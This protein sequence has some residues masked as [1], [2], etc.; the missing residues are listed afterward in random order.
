M[1]DELLAV[2]AHI[3]LERENSG[4]LFAGFPD[5]L[6]PPS[7]ERAYAIQERAADLRIK[8][9]GSALA[10]YKIGS[11]TPVMQ[12][13][14]GIANPCSGTMIERTVVA[15]GATFEV[16][17][18]GV[19]GVECELAVRLARD[20]PGRELPYSHEEL[21][22]AVAS[23]MAAIELVEDRYVDWRALDAATLIADNFFHVGAVL[24]VEH[25]DFDPRRLD[26]TAGEMRLDGALV[27]VG[28]GSDVLGHPLTA[29]GWLVSGPGVRAEG[30]RAGQVIML[31]S[32][33]ETHWVVAG[34]TVRIDNDLLGSVEVSFT[35]G[36]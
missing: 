31:G 24:G 29:L 4:D 25:T 9:T 34:M 1:T 7:E 30:L 26:E 14:L 22:D 32:L 13:Y 8:N 35:G 5:S 17:A 36:P 16:P 20:L 21:A 27:G 18:N 28:L 23:C 33:V 19:L 2:A 15:S 12:A 6:R 3:L 10:G 11:T